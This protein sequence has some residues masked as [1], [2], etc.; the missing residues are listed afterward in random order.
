MS[1][2]KIDERAAPIRAQV[3]DQPNEGRVG[4]PAHGH[5]PTVEH[6]RMHMTPLEP[7][8][9]DEQYHCAEDNPF[10]VVRAEQSPERLGM[11]HKAGDAL[12]N[13]D[14]VC[15]IT[16]AKENPAEADKCKSDQDLK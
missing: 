10:Y 1:E 12:Q 2:L 7:F 5:W 11:H 16:G 8:E 3:Q 6:Q 4:Q 9:K 14:G 13:R 15:K